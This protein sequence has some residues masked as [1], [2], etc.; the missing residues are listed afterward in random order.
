M[1]HALDFD[2]V[3]EYD[4]KDSGIALP[5][6]LKYGQQEVKLNAKIDTGSTFC[7]F[8]RDYGEELGLDIERGIEEKIALANGSF[9]TTYGHFIQLSMFGLDFEPIAHFAKYYDF[10]KNVLGRVGWLNQIKLAIIDYEN[11]LYVSHYNSD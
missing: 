8:Q 4:S 11:L 6:V 9:L 2:L 3:F 7:V 10:H 1:K 5:I